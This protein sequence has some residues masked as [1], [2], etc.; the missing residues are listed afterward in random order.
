VTLKVSDQQ[1]AD[2]TSRRPANASGNRID[3][4]ELEAEH[5]LE[6]SLSQAEATGVDDIIESDLA[7]PKTSTV[8]KAEPKR[9]ALPGGFISG[10]TKAII[11][12]EK[13][14]SYNGYRGDR[15]NSN[16]KSS[17]KTASVAQAGGSQRRKSKRQRAFDF[18]EVDIGSGND[19]DDGEM[20]VMPTARHDRRSLPGYIQ[21]R[22]DVE[23]AMP[24][25]LPDNFRDFTHHNR[26]SD[27]INGPVQFDGSPDSPPAPAARAS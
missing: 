24:D 22:R 18:E 8:A 1:L 5:E 13:D 3:A 16:R 4:S 11:P 27:A 20:E 23:G 15:A 12:V 17:Q 14:E 9:P 25:E 10:T 19:E 2:I 21:H 26:R 7:P 6:D